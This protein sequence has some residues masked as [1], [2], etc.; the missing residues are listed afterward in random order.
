MRGRA[1]LDLSSGE[2]FDHEHRGA[3]QRTSPEWRRLALWIRVGWDGLRR[4]GWTSGKQL[5][6]E[7]KQRTAAAAGE[8]TEVPDTN[9]A[10]RQHMQQEAT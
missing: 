6:T 2:S 9:E 8:E 7:R 10:T 5:L 4:G 3:A 1:E